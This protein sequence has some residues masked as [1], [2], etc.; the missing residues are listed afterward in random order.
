MCE[1]HFAFISKRLLC[2]GRTHSGG[3]Q[4]ITDKSWKQ[5]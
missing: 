4:F 1:Y 2:V 3:S 5:K